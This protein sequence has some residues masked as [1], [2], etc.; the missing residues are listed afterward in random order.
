M[1]MLLYNMK[2]RITSFDMIEGLP[3]VLFFPM[4]FL[5]S[6]QKIEANFQI[7]QFWSVM[8]QRYYYIFWYEKFIID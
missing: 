1:I 4:Y 6:T 8:S 7:L 2:L 3:C 5:V